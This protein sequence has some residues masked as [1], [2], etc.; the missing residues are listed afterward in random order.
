MS[1]LGVIGDVH[2]DAARLERLLALPEL[3]DRNIVM[4]GD[5]VDR[6]EQSAAVLS[7]LVDLRRVLGDGLILLQGN[8]ELAFLRY[9]RDG[10][11]AAFGRFGGL[12]T[13]R[14]YVGVAAGDVRA[15]LAADLP[16]DHLRLLTESL[17]THWETDDMLLSHAGYDP[18]RPAARTQQALVESSH[19]SLFDPETVARTRPRPLVVCGHYVQRSGKPYD[20]AGFVCVDTGCGTTGGPLTALLLPEHTFV[21]VA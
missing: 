17:L 20:V 4:L 10:D 9:V 8:H 2:G 5:F 1:Q 16:A 15:Q 6:G 12:A 19:P 13:I 21:A 7:L 3:R 14:S 11:L 18:V